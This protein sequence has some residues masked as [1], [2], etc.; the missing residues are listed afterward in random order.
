MKLTRTA[1]REIIKEELSNQE[2][3]AKLYDLFSAGNGAQAEAFATSLGKNDFFAGRE[4]VGRD[5]SGA[6]MSNMNLSKSDLH[7][8]TL[9]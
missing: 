4:F 5:F 7:L 2:I 6:E 3:D 9:F 1:L 8:S